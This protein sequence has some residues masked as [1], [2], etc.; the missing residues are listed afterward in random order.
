MLL[1]SDAPSP[2]WS[3][4]CDQC[5]N[6]YAYAPMFFGCPACAQINV[7]GVLD[8][9]FHPLERPRALSQRAGSRGSSR[10]RDLISGVAAHDWI[11]IGEGDT[12]LARS[13]KI[14]PALGLNNLFFKIEAQ[15]P[16]GSFKDRYVCAAIN[17]AVAFGHS[18]IVTSS[19][20]NMGISV[21]AYSAT[22]GLRC[23]LIVPTTTPPQVINEAKRLGAHVYRSLPE[24]RI[25][26]LD[27]LT[28]DHGWY[29]IGP[30]FRRAIQNPFA[31]DGYKTFAY[32]LIEDLGQEPQFV[33][34]PCARGNGLHGTW[35]GFLDARSFG[36]CDGAPA[37]VACQPASANSL[38]VSVSHGLSYSAQVPRQ[39]SVAASAAEVVSSDGALRAI[40]SSNGTALSASEDSILSAVDQLITEGCFVEPSSALPV[41][42]L[43]ELIAQHQPAAD[44]IIVCVLTGTGMRWVD[45]LTDSTATTPDVSDA[46]QI[47]AS[48]P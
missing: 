29:P 41:A 26:I 8:P 5:G 32:E 45:P 1:P 44:A 4:V 46:T 11:S 23:V 34:F 42:C 2:A 28:R 39:Y 10:F 38:V 3:L 14:G 33:L 13:Q 30:S 20:G 21:A 47:I 9:E 43:P 6:R 25:D 24:R 22:A 35:K 31:T 16:S 7:T 36:W 27:A 19:T 12:R 40:R 15:N 17:A 37:M 18:D 48:L